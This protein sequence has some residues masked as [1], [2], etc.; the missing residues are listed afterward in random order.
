MTRSKTDKSNPDYDTFLSALRNVLSVPHSEIKQ[1]W[2]LKRELEKRK[3]KK[4][5][6]SRA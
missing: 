6:A 4:S 3:P 2:M 1:N 5:S